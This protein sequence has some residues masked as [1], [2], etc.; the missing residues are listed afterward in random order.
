MIDNNEL[1][2]SINNI[3]RQLRVN[4]NEL[5]NR[6]DNVVDKLNALSLLLFKLPITKD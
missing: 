1:E 6:I 3:S 4:C 5:K 2:Y